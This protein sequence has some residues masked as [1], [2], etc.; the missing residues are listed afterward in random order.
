MILFGSV[1]RN[2]KRSF[3]IL[4]WFIRAVY[5]VPASSTRSGNSSNSERPAMYVLVRWLTLLALTVGGLAESYA[6]QT[7]E[8]APVQVTSG[9]SYVSIGRWD[10]DRLNRIL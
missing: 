4:P 3:V 2:A 8:A 1:V 5:G 10:V 9:I 6:A 7:N